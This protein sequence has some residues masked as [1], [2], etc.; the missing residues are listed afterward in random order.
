M[1]KFKNCLIT[2][3]TGSG[4]S[5]LYEKILEKDKNIIIYGT[6]R[7]EKKLR[8]LK[9]R[10]DSKRLK[11]IKLNLK[12]KTKI[13]RLLLKI[14]PDLIFNLAFIADVRKSFDL[15]EKIM[16]NNYLLTV[17]LLESLR[18]LNLK[19]LLIIC[20]SSEVYGDV[21]KNETPIKENQ[22]MRPVSPYAVSKA[23]Q[24][25]ISQVYIES[26]GLNII[27][28]RMFSYTNSRRENLFM[29]AF[30]KQL[31]LIEKGNKQILH[32][33]NLNS[34]RC[35][36]DIDDAMNAYWMTALY[37][38]IG[39]TYNIGGNQIISV[40]QYLKQL[41]KLSTKK[42]KTKLDPP[43]LRPQDVTYQIPDVSKF[44]KDVNWQPK[45]TF[46]ESV[47]NLLYEFRK[48]Y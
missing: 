35:F 30:A 29:S 45:I 21:K 31:V 6:Y 44:K 11:F 17:N 23:F 48:K 34:I 25:L 22:P 37:G 20:S 2:G 18:V 39:E 36:Q 40:K 12:D 1:R 15:P 28:T 42:I 27:I 19:S 32:H 8:E 7:S 38:K 14:K 16:T 13:K 33:G 24:D 5:Y 43:R 9:K 4:G 3:I 10:K 26:Y 47:K 41:I 46:K